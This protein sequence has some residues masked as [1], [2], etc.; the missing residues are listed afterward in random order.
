MIGPADDVTCDPSP[1]AKGASGPGPARPEGPDL[2]TVAVG[3]DPHLACVYALA[4][5]RDASKKTEYGDRAIEQLREA[6]KAGY[7]NAKHA[8]KDTGLDPLRDRDDF[9]AWLADLEAKSAMKP[10]PKGA[11]P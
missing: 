6:V 8:S 11:K 3:S 10:P 7:D 4:G 2:G 5:A 9:K 1:T